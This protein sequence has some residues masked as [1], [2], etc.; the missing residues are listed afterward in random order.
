MKR[1]L[2][3]DDEF[4]HTKKPV[5]YKS[6]KDH[7][8]VVNPVT[9]YWRGRRIRV[10]PGYRYDG[11]SI[12]RM[13]WRLIGNPWEEYEAAALIHD[14]LYDSE[15]WEREDAD[16][17]FRDLMEWLGV[18]KWRLSLMY[19]AVRLGGGPTWDKHTPESVYSARQFLE[20]DL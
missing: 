18:A 20:V 11:A 5:R 4:L 13:F 14:I 1:E 12:P 15:I 9:A 8:V 16:Q 6:G 7:R 10:L 17:C 3:F 2:G 19:R